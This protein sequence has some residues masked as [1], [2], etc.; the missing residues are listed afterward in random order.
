MRMTLEDDEKM[1]GVKDKYAW[2]I[3]DAG[4]LFEVICMQFFNKENVK[5]TISCEKPLT[6]LPDNGNQDG[7]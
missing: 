1:I 4:S 2:T 6:I 5:V 3:E 7:M